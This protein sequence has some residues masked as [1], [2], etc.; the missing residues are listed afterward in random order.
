LNGSLLLGLDGE[1]QRKD[2]QSRQDKEGALS[3]HFE[4]KKK[5]FL[6]CLNPPNKPKKYA[7]V[8]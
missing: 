1:T 4:E 3:I 2:E 5:S 8:F 6:L 7:S